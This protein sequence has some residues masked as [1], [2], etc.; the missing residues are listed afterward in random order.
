VQYEIPTRKRGIS[1]R[2]YTKHMTYYDKKILPTGPL[3]EEEAC[4]TILK[5][6]KTGE[7]E[8]CP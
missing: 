4:A 6:R 7:E 1:C 5:E 3:T 8:I 2:I